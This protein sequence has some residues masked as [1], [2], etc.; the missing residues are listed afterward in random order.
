MLV[1]ETK[2][3]NNILGAIH[4]VGIGGI[5]MSGIAEI[6]FNLGY[7]IQG[8]DLVDNPNTKR[9]S[10]KGIKI[11]IGHS[12][13]NIKDV[14]YLV[15]S[16]AI[17]P[18]NPELIEAIARKIPIIK[19]SQM[20]AE[21]MR[22]KFSIAIS[23]SH[24]KTTTTSLVACLFEAAGLDPTVINGG[25]INNK[26]TNAYLGT[27]EYLV[28]EADE[29]DATFINIPSTVA[30]VTNID[31][32]HMDYYKTCES[33]NNAFKSFLS[34]L[35]FYGFGVVCIDHPVVRSIIKE[36]KD[37]RIIT[38]GIES[39]DADIIAYNINLS[40]SSSV[41][42]IKIR[43][44][45]CSSVNI[46]E[47]ITIPIPG[48]HNVLNALAAIAVGVE[49][50]FGI[51][52]LQNG[53]SRFQGVNRRFTKIGSYNN[54]DII[55]D[56]AHH[57]VEIKATLSTARVALKKGCSLIAIFQPHRYNR[58]YNLFDEF[59]EAFA[60]AD[61]IFVLD[62]YGAGEQKI[63]GY[64]SHNLSNALVNKGKDAEYISDKN[65]I[66]KIIKNH[67]K[68]WDLVVCMGAGDISYLCRAALQN[69]QK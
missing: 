48:Y 67:A 43:F 55:D 46:I 35:P 15:I 24:G 29:S 5:G 32:E 60:D 9:L 42:D 33:L 27:S 30:V 39:E 2:R 40:I 58:L 61:K 26:N 6:L 65:M 47:K 52:V 49:L 51:K 21:L 54:I 45:N 11:I 41:F 34:N 13:A 64:D 16:S 66:D 53:F 44:P 36:I 18:D 28:V 59:T 17:K 69:L 62:V 63:D 8:S 12:A 25:I 10:D 50:D 37:K 1:L 57:P 38:Y 3:K 7:K 31:P 68:P 19:R 23:G 20:L 4:F 14:A 22:L 56:Y